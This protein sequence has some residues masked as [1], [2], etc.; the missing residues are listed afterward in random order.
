MSRMC[1]FAFEGVLPSYCRLDGLSSFN[2]SRTHPG[3][4]GYDG[5]FNI[6][7]DSWSSPNH[8]PYVAMTVHFTSERDGRPLSMLLDL[9]EVAESHTG[10]NLGIAFVNVLKKFG[11]EEKVSKS[12]CDQG[13]GGYS[14]VACACRFLALL[15]ITH[16][17]TMG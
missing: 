1:S 10:V 8:N 2:G 16:P 3:P 9:V 7:T 17:T 14:P 4:K 13:R 12:N 15:V 11:I 5:K 6:A